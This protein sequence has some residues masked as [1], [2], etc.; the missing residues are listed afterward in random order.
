MSF[1]LAFVQL[2][3]ISTAAVD[4]QTQTL[5]GRSS[6]QLHSELLAEGNKPAIV[7]VNVLQLRSR[8]R[9]LEYDPI[10]IGCTVIR[11]LRAKQGNNRQTE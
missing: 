4:T 6:K 9:A 8:L 2:H 7:P 11:D 1:A 3:V 10:G 5:K